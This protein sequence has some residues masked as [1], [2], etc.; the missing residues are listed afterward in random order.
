MQTLSDGFL[1]YLGPNGDYCGSRGVTTANIWDS[2][3]IGATEVERSESESQHRSIELPSVLT[4][5][6][7]EGLG[8]GF[9]HYLGLIGAYYGSRGLEK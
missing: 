9:L 3:W 4:R 5:E 2:G 6:G 8:E 1:H 7:I